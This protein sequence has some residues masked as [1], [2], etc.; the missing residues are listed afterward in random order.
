MTLPAQ[1]SDDAVGVFQMAELRTPRPAFGVRHLLVFV[2][3][4]AVVVGWWAD[5]RQMQRQIHRS[6]RENV[7]AQQRS[8]AAHEQ[9][10]AFRISAESEK[11]RLDDLV[12]LQQHFIDRYR[13][14]LSER[15]GQSN[16][17]QL[18]EEFESNMRQLDHF[19]AGKKPRLRLI[20]R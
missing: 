12:R 16:D 18:I 4:T 15:I 2:A 9:T 19:T 14:M 20:S 1:F 13:A 6:H 8:L 5:R 7:E 3:F 17:P 11:R 10:Y